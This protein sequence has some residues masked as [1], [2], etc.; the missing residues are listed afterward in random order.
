MSRPQRAPPAFVLTYRPLKSADN[1]RETSTRD[2]RGLQ[3]QGHLPTRAV[4]VSWLAD[5]FATT[6]AAADRSAAQTFTQ[7]K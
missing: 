6:G 7:G 4:G 1:P 3:P 2:V 5:S